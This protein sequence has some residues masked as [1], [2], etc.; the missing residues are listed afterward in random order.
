[1]NAWISSSRSAIAARCCSST[2]TAE[3]SPDA[4]RRGDVDGRR[5]RIVAAI[6]LLLPPG[7]PDDRRHLE[8]VVLDV[9]CGREHLVAVEPGRGNVVA[10]HVRQRVRLGHRHDVVELQLV[11]V[12]EVVEHVA[13]LS[14]GAFELLGA[15]VEPGQTGHLGHVVDGDAC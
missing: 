10:Q 14:R 11:D 12:R 9:R 3:R 4:D 2:S 1:M 6:I 7:Q 5:L 13:E 8:A 15:Q